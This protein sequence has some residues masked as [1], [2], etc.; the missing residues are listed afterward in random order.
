MSD[1]SPGF[2][3]RRPAEAEMTLQI[4][5]MADIFTIILVFLLKSFAT[6]SVNINPSPGLQLPQ[7]RTGDAQVEAL[8]VEISQTTI[9]VE[10]NPVSSLKGFRFDAK[11]LN[12]SGIPVSLDAAFERQKKRQ[13]LIAQSNSDVQLDKKMLVVAD[14]RTPYL[15]LKSVL[16]VAAVHGYSDF[17]LVVV[18]KE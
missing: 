8:T 17:K 4:T 1:S 14:Q 10:N 11:D 3:V 7:A 15:T 13:E 2:K 16:S 18:Q 12:A 9:Q 6:G 5:S